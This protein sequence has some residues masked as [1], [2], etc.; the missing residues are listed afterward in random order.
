MDWF[1]SLEALWDVVWE[2]MQ[3]YPN[4]FIAIA[5]GGLVVLAGEMGAR[6]KP[7]GGSYDQK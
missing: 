1:W 4:G 3:E 7:K 6:I 5:V 2:F